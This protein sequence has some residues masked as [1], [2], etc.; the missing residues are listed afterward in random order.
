MA[1]TLREPVY[2][3]A[4][5]SERTRDRAARASNVAA[6]KAVAGAV[7][8]TLGP[9]GMD[10]MLVDST[11]EVVV[12]ND[13]ATILAEMDVAHPAA[14][15]LV[16]V[17]ESQEDETGDGT[18]TAAVLAG[19]LLVRAE[20]LL[21]RDVHPTTVV[22]GYA[23]AADIATDTV[24]GL[25]LGDR[26]DDDLLRRVAATSLTGKGT[27][28]A[29]TET[30]ADLVVRAVRA[31]EHADGRVDE[32]D[33]RVLAR[34][35]GG[36][37][38]TRLVEGVVLDKKRV[39]DGAPRTVEDARVAVVDV[40]LDVRK[41]SVD[42]H[43]QI[44][45]VSQLDAALAAEDRE[46]RGY[47]DTLAEAGVTVL[48]STKKVSDRVAGRLADHGIVAYQRVRGEDA[49]AV[50]RATGAARL[51]DV[52]EVD[53]DDLGVADRVRVERVG[54]DELT[55]VE[56]GEAAR[57]VTIFVRGG[58]DHVVREVERAVGDAVDVV[59]AALREGVAPGAG[60]TEAAVAAAI[61]DAAA[62]VEGRKQLAVEAFAAAVE[63]V[64]R[65]LAQ[66]A[67]L[68][69]IDAVVDLRAATERGDR[70]G[71]VVDEAGAVRIADPVETGVL[72][73]VAVKIGA[74]GAATEAATMILR[75]DDV[76][77]A[78]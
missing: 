46:L 74:V 49:R 14:Q 3:I 68:D 73:P 26:V 7:R 43:Y 57:S 36:A 55:F 4:S 59:R 23:E 70:V 17:A 40:A 66:N 41:G 78:S 34:A 28:S 44:D 35:G 33:V 77:A 15:M 51:G 47:A 12:T 63:A 39:D 56:G 76:V 48:V 61:R 29:V 27:G 31:T 8:S 25:R 2:M 13:G 24:L 60:A 67:G 52:R 19:E 58:T 1:S 75:I 38:E 50:A 42:S 45:S 71:I 37:S 9:R 21:D 72:D 16:E 11:G 20:D 5:G 22:E 53:P 69:P 6:G 64:P 54:D 30:L 32:D 62:G 18:T 10:K 65:T